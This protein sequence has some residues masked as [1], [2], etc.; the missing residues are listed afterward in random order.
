MAILENETNNYYR[1]EYD[2]SYIK[3]GRVIVAFSTYKTTEDRQKEKDRADGIT[4]FARNIHLL[5]TDKY[6]ELVDNIQALDVEPQTIACSED[7]N[8]IDSERYPEL[9]AL[10]LE[11]EMLKDFASLF[12]ENCFVY[13]NSAHSVAETNLSTQ[14]LESLG[15]NDEWQTDPIQLT[16]RAEVYCGDYNGE[17]ITHEF[18]YER[19]KTVMNDNIEDC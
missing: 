5:A 8:I 6:K 19:L 15:Y 9:R 1:V 7:S 13:G 17:P 4:A 11:I 16:N 3:G 2:E 18:F 12:Y 14:L 10:Q